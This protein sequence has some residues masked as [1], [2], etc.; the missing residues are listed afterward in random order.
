MKKSKGIILLSILLVL[1]MTMTAFADTSEISAVTKGGMTASEMLEKVSD[2]LLEYKTLKYVLE[3]DMI[4][5][6][7]D[8]TQEEAEEE[9]AQ[10]LAM[11]MIMNAA[12]DQENDKLYIVNTV[13]TEVEEEAIE[14][15][16]EMLKQGSVM[17]MKLPGADKWMQQDLNPIMQ[18]LEALLGTN[19]Q[20]GTGATKQQME[21]FG[22]T[23]AYLEDEKIDEEDYYVIL[24]T[25]D[26]E[27]FK[28]VIDEILD[29][30]MILAMEM[31]G[32]EELNEVEEEG[33]K[34]AVEAMIAEM[35]KSMDIEVEYKYYINKETKILEKIDFQQ[36]IRMEMGIIEQLTKATGAFQY[37][38]FDE[39]VEIPE[40]Q[41]EDIMD[42]GDMMSEI[43][44]TTNEKIEEI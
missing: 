43:T 30:I 44:F 37:Y 16:T 24:I 12:M 9:I 26:K 4:S 27:M 25:V 15:S 18:E 17:Y 36:T 22:M 14:V 34:E 42:L 39:P 6:V 7:I 31:A 11:K 29:K 3:M 28:A 38:D 35:I 33:M 41:P 10:E 23:A 5:S 20:N 21:L 40:I 13:K 1:S 32:V 2:E 19:I 8:K